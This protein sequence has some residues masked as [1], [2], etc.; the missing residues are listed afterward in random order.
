MSTH[1]EP[2]PAPYTEKKGAGALG[3]VLEVKQLWMQGHGLVRDT[4]QWRVLIDNEHRPEVES[5]RFHSQAGD[6]R[7]KQ[8]CIERGQQALAAAVE[9]FS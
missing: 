1:T 7:A 6:A 4:W 8:V 3:L 5:G 9:R 2:A